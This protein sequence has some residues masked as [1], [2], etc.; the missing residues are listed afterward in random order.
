M[1]EWF[2]SGHF[3]VAAFD[4][5]IVDDSLDERNPG[6]GEGAFGLPGLRAVKNSTSVSAT[7]G[8]CRAMSP[9]WV[10]EARSTARSSASEKP[11][12]T[13]SSRRIRAIAPARSS[14]AAMARSSEAAPAV[15]SSGGRTETLPGPVWWTSIRARSSTCSPASRSRT[16]MV[17]ATM[18]PYDQPSSR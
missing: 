18:P 7:P 5:V 15:R 16:A 12:R 8:T 3:E 13:G 6:G 2:G 9:A 17:W 10:S 1:C 11:A 4:G 14:E